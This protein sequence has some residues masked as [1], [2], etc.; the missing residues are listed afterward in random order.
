[1]KLQRLSICLLFT[2]Y[3]GFSRTILPAAAPG[4]LPEPAAAAAEA[5][6]KRRSPQGLPS[7][8]N[9]KIA[10][11]L[12]AQDAAEFRRTIRNVRDDMAYIHD[13]HGIFFTPESYID[14]QLLEQIKSLDPEHKFWPAK[15]IPDQYKAEALI[16]LA[17]KNNHSALTKAVVTYIKAHDE[18]CAPLRGK[19]K[20]MRAIQSNDLPQTLQLLGLTQQ[21]DGTFVNLTSPDGKRVPSV[22]PNGLKFLSYCLSGDFPLEAKTMEILSNFTEP[23]GYKFVGIGSTIYFA[24]KNLSIVQALLQHRNQ[25]GE[26]DVDVN[27]KDNQGMTALMWAVFFNNR[28]AAQAL[29]FHHNQQGVLDVDVNAK[30]DLGETVLMRAV[31]HQSFPIVRVLLEHRNQQGELDVDVN[32]KDN[33]DMTA[34]ML[35]AQHGIVSMVQALL[36]HRN[37]QE[38][39]DV[40]V[41]AKDNQG[42][43]ALMLA[44]QHG[45]VSMVQA[46]L[47]HHNQQG[48]LDVDVNAKSN[49]GETA[50][51]WAAKSNNIPTLQMLLVHRNQ[52]GEFD[53]DVNA[54]DN[55]GYTALM[56]AAWYDNL[57]FVQALLLNARIN[58]NLRNK[59]GRTAYEIA[60]K[61]G[62]FSIALMLLSDRRTQVSWADIGSLL[63]HVPKKMGSAVLGLVRQHAR[64][65]AFAITAGAFAW[66]YFAHYTNH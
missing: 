46:L 48:V 2:I 55:L 34:L 25:Q 37:Q 8:I 1:M 12:P 10:Q 51:M 38:V 61:N 27:A 6:S 52:Q 16:A 14:K 29:L 7:V 35:A 50:L 63:S 5:Q 36:E 40:D 65:A 56:H 21:A 60:V 18:I 66:Y 33:Q 3:L 24:A 4:R 43:T 44:A 17:V 42:M 58:V 39:L 20:L 9:R 13:D 53:L 49:L 26:L 23:E 47:F 57:P 31:K 64:T 11:F 15:N 45:I 62:H 32:A 59:D 22:D 54:K 28:P 19:V 41:N 30:S